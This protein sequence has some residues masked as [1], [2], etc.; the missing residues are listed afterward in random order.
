VN[1]RVRKQQQQM[2]PG[3]GCPAQIPGRGQY[4]HSSHR[5]EIEEVG[6]SHKDLREHTE[7][8][9]ETGTGRAEGEEMIS[10]RLTL[11]AALIAA[12]FA[13]C[14]TYF[15]TPSARVDA[16][17][18]LP[19]IVPTKN[20]ER[21]PTAEEQAAAAFERAAKTILKRLPD[22]MAYAGADEPPITGHIPLPKRRPIPR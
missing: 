7:Y 8:T 20:I 5:R 3:R 19:P 2:D 12:A 11:L 17:Q 14:L 6:P 21:R 16:D 9:D 22:A 18:R 15:V 1:R 13:G 10:L 4:V